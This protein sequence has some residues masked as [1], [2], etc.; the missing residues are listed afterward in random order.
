MFK[1]P[2]SSYNQQELE[3]RIL[4]FWE[5]RGTFGKLVEKNK[6]GKRFS[7]LDGPI[8]AN[9]MMGVHHAWG[10]TYK[11]IFV[12]YKSMRGY[13]QRYQ[14]GFDCQGLWVEVEVEKDLGLNSKREIREFGLANF[15]RRCRERVLRYA[16]IITEQSKRL[17]QWMDWEKSY[18]TMS[19]TNI[20]YI[21]LFLKR[22]S[23]NG[24]LYKGRHVMPWCIRCGTSLS[25]HEMVDSY[26]ELEHPSVFLRLPIA[27]REN[28]YFMVWTTTP[29]T[30]AANTALAVNP[31][32]SYVK[33]RHN[34][35]FVY[36]S[37]GT[38]RQV[39]PGAELVQEVKGE[40]LA[41]LRYKGPFDE[42]AA[43]SGIDHRVVCDRMVGEAE[44]T[45]IVH[46]APGCGAEDFEI[47]RREGIGL[48]DPVD[49][50]G[51]YY[52]GF[53]FLSGKNVSE[54]APLV[55]DS[56]RE[57]GF[58]VRAEKFVHR[59][60]VCWRCAEELIF[61]L[62]EEWFI[63]CE[64]LREPLIEAARTVNWIPDYMG[65]RMEDWLVNMQDW[66]IS[67]RRFW[68]LPLP[69]YQCQ[70]CSHVTV[71]GSREELA[72][73]AGLKVE[74]L[75]ELHRPWIDEIRIRCESCGGEAVRIEDVGDCWLDAGIVPFS[76]LR[77]VEDRAYWEKWFPAEFICEMREQIRL[78]FY[79]LLFMSVTLEGCAPYKN[80]LIYEKV[81]DEHGNPMHK[82]LNNVIW[83]DEA[84]ERMGADIMRW[85]FASHNN[86]YNINFGFGPGKQIKRRLLT[87][88]NAY[89]FF[90]LYASIDQPSVTP[91]EVVGK[92]LTQ[93]DRWI[94]SRLFTVIRRVTEAYDRYN[95]MGVVKAVEAFFDDL[96]NWYIRRNRRRFWRA[97]SDRDKQAAYQTLYTVLVEVCKLIGPIV[98]FLAEEMYQSLVATVH[99]DAPESVHL[100][101]FPAVREDLID[102][103]LEEEVAAAR[104]V[105]RLGL[106]ARNKAG[107][108]VRQP[109]ARVLVRAA[110]SV[111]QERLDR[112]AG[113]I[114]EELNVKELEYIDSLEGVARP[115]VRFNLRNV[116][117]RLGAKMQ[118]AAAVLE[119][120]QD[121]IYEQVV[122][123]K[124]V[125][126]QVGGEVLDFGPEDFITELVGVGDFSVAAEGELVVALYTAL[127][128]ELVAEGFIREL[129]RH[130]Q[131]MRK[132]AGFEVQDRIDLYVSCERPV[133]S[134][135]E[136]SVEFVRRETLS[137]DVVFGAGP[138]RAFVKS[139]R[140]PERFRSR[141][142]LDSDKMVIGVIKR[143]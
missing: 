118:E 120:S 129:V 56:L 41:G 138:E 142:G 140:V 99:K 40:R 73:R 91:F 81:F 137:V 27:G 76:T 82:S 29:W 43:Q 97:S 115:S 12:R 49:E 125:T 55:Y 139:V 22:C 14:N 33:A 62:V 80:V 114:V 16:G 11:D 54:V 20:E 44:G 28:E 108:K 4:R 31:E 52:E 53:G 51:R 70:D 37:K 88:W 60:P 93:L 58:L 63:K 21:W 98:P 113:D 42:L 77:Y 7:F 24:W 61:R 34:G 48:V 90:L 39:L 103:R 128:E 116:G 105:V 9:N 85:L 19:D 5:E 26:R 69:F 136:A 72:R 134:V 8:T 141:F 104:S 84:A 50:D 89:T 83:F 18:Y 112:F 101:D 23:E 119:A 25:H 45:G 123:G 64:Q 32:L 92:D 30:L 17:G 38:A 35:G 65:K 6:S 133:Q 111:G 124:P 87:L 3:R 100:C 126:L 110:S 96:A 68:G 135:V 1:K 117:P 86:A 130:I 74:E 59:Y 71:V 109:L 15:S 10:R 131:V 106:S 13:H 94:L 132:E 57:K 95:A 46:I 79:S 75:P 107:I 47:Y 122:S 127:S 143:G 36:L 102:S 78:W 66:C 67:R 121:R 2:P